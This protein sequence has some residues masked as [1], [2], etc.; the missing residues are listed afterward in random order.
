MTPY[1]QTLDRDA[2]GNFRQLLYDIT[3]NAAMGNYLDMNGNTKTR[4]NENYAREV[5]QLFSIG[6]VRLNGD[7]T[8]QLDGLGQPIPTYDQ[9]VVTNFARVFTGWRLAAGAAGVPNYVAPMILN[10]SQHDTGSKTLLNG[11]A[12]QAGQSADKDLSDGLDNIFNDSN[13]GPF[14]G[15]QLIQHLVTSNPS[16][17]YVARVAAA[18][19]G[20]GGARGD[21][22]AVVRAILLDPEARGAVKTAPSYGRLRNPV[23]LMLGLLRA[24]HARSADLGGDSDGYLNPQAVLMGMD[25]FRP[26]SVF[27]YYSPAAAVPGA[28]GLRGPEFGL[29]STSTAVQ[30]DNVVNT[31][32]FSRIPVSANAP[33]GTA[34][35]LRP[36]QQL[37]STP[38]QLADALDAL[39]LHATM[40]A[41]MRQSVVDAVNAVPAST[42]A[43]RVQAAVYLVATS[44]QYQVER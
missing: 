41:E 12:M 36:L 31:L 38:P 19:N 37:A 30:R 44:S 29:L 11:Y 33:T 25:V 15:K 9:A 4:P 42:P 1:L 8:T 28:A 20:M 22:R 2:F 6:T 21:L 34:L 24:F 3:L 13:V 43:R 7:G 39:L 5:L 40:S 32:V 10:A 14:I 26:A 23:Q 35:D 18:F 16:P 17:A 27:S